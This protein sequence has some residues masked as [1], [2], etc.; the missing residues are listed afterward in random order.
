MLP[1]LLWWLL[2]GGVPGFQGSLNSDSAQPIEVF[3][4][5]NQSKM[6]AGSRLVADRVEGGALSGKGSLLISRKEETK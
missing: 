2:K 4:R 3:P 1:A 5:R 6:R